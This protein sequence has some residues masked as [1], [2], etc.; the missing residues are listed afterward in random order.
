MSRYEEEQVGRLIEKIYQI[1]GR[2]LPK[3]DCVSD[4][5]ISYLEYRKSHGKNFRCRWERVTEYMIDEIRQIRK[6]RNNRI[7]L[8]S[9]LSLDQS[10]C[11]N[12]EDIRSILFP[13]KG[14]FTKGVILWDYAWHLGVEKSRI[15]RY[16]VR[17][18]DDSYIM[19]KL[20]L[21]E[22]RYREL[23]TE[24]REDMTVYINS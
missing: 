12:D 5:W 15:L 17:D 8:E 18:E 11:D 20:G 4:C 19:R 3:A 10:F 22:Q 9:R 23:K 14:D 6:L 24:L 2:G 16:M 7:R 21:S 13:A 1:Y